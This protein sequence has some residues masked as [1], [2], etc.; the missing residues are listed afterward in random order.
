M[1]RTPVETSAVSYHGGL[2]ASTPITSPETMPEDAGLDSS[3]EELACDWLDDSTVELLLPL[4]RQI[5]DEYLGT[6]TKTTSLLE[7]CGVAY[8]QFS[9]EAK[10]AVDFLVK[11]T[12]VSVGGTT[13]ASAAMFGMKQLEK[14][15][16]DRHRR[17]MERDA[18]K[19]RQTLAEVT[20]S[21]ETTKQRLEE[22]EKLVADEE[23]SLVKMQLESKSKSAIEK[24]K[25]RA[26][27][28][29]AQLKEFRDLPPDT[30]EAEAV[31]REAQGE[32]AALKRQLKTLYKP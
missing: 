3:E 10:C 18:A 24:K 13:A 9:D 16:K 4:A 5:S 29:E 28:L 19:L 23:L 27:S 17:K 21:L 11:Q 15:S 12:Q 6:E 1:S 25:K 26:D 22:F 14:I 8:H 7:K 30:A 32:L 20:L 2:Q 31:L